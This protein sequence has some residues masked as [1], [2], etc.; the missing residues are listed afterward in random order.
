MKKRVYQVTRTEPRIAADIGNTQS[1]TA[2]ADYSR[3]A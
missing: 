2:I 1:S 3:E